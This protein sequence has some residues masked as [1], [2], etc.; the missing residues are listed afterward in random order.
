MPE[1]F[2]LLVF[3]GRFQPVHS[4]HLS[5]MQAALH[6]AR[7]LLVLV[8]STNVTRSTKNP[9]SFAERSVMI[10]A[11]MGELES[12]VQ[13]CPI[14]DYPYM[15]DLW[16]KGVQDAVQTAALELGAQSIGLIGHEKDESSYYLRMFPQWPLVESPNIDGRSATEL[17][18]LILAP[19]GRGSHLVLESA[20]PSACVEFVEEF[21]RLPQYQRLVNEHAFLKSYHRQFAS[22]PYPPVF[23]TVDAVVIHSG[24]ILLVERKAEPGKGLLALPGGFIDQRER[25]ADGMLRELKEETNIKIPLPVL[26]GSIKSSRVFDDPDRSQRG[27]TITHAFHIEFPGGEL[28]RIKGGDDAAKAVW[29]PLS[30]FYALDGAMY[31]DHWHIAAGFIGLT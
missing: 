12:R 8:G 22:Y 3:I 17:R 30:D 28:P 14:K 16:V 26:R 2:D 9:F 11:S 5:I 7:R 27:R 29:L 1:N 18:D 19:N 20:M 31:E 24:H 25:I 13:V 6:R 23:V 21:R 4:S 15:E 10:R